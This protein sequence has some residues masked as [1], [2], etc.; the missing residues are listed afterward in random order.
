MLRIVYTSSHGA[1]ARVPPAADGAPWEQGAVPAGMAPC[2]PDSIVSAEP[3]L[4][5]I[6]R[7]YYSSTISSLLAVKQSLPVY[8]A[9]SVPMSNEKWLREAVQLAVKA[10]IDC[11]L[12]PSPSA[13]SVPVVSMATRPRKVSPVLIFSGVY[14]WI[15]VHPSVSTADSFLTN[16]CSLTIF[17]T[18]GQICDFP[19]LAVHPS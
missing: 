19:E 11:S 17:C 3:A 2:C 7:G 1:P 5:R 10:S 18:L 13:T 14:S 6:F 8:P 4:S 16:A 15:L 9:G 12:M